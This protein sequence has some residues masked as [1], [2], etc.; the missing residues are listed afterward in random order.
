MDC[1][2]L[3]CLTD[4][5][6]TFVAAAKVAL[7]KD[8][9]PDSLNQ[10]PL[11]EHPVGT[12]AIRTEMVYMGREGGLRSGDWFYSPKQGPMGLFGT[13]YMK[14]MGFKNSDYDGNDLR[15]DAQPAQLY[16]VKD[17]VG[18]TT[19]LYSKYPEIAAQ[20][21]ARLKEILRQRKSR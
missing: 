2:K 7:P 4:L 21:D 20:M 17:D 15:Q 6:A 16:N 1:D 18:Q 14:Q 12:P 13:F 9:A 3:L 10:L 5:F 8:A 19:N 11:L